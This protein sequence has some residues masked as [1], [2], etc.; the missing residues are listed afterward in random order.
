MTWRTITAALPF[1][2]LVACRG[3]VEP[4]IP[5]SISFDKPD[6][7]V[8]LS[9]DGTQIL[10]TTPG[11]VT[12]VRGSDPFPA[13]VFIYLLPTTGNCD[14]SNPGPAFP[15]PKVATAY[16][17]EAMKQVSLDYK[18]CPIL[19][20]FGYPRGVTDIEAQYTSAGKTYTAHATLTVQ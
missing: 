7:L 20:P 17:D 13:L 11:T 10:S 4:G 18:I 1:L 5:P 6:Y 3:N 15:S 12:L 14:S 8:T 16:P 9:D 19:T 2:L